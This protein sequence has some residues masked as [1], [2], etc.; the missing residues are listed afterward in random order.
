MSLK[1]TYSIVYE[2]PGVVFLEKI[3]GVATGAPPPVR[4][5]VFLKSTE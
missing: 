3:T 4:V 2:L 1:R 5:K